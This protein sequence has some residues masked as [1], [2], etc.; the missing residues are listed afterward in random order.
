V[1]DKRYYFFSLLALLLILGYL[2]YLILRPFL[3]PIGWAFV[4]SIVFFPMHRFLLRFLKWDSLAAAATAVM[5]CVLIL[6]PFSYFTYL[7]T[8]E[9]SN[10]SVQPVN[11]K[12]M[13]KILTHP[14]IAP[15]LKKGLAFLDLSQSQLQAS[16]VKAISNAGQ[17]LLEYIP[18]GL[19][20]VA[21]AA[22]HFALMAFALFFFLRDGPQF[23]A[24][25]GD[26]VPFSTKNKERLTVQ[27][28]D[29]VVSTIYGGIIVAI[30]QGL[31]GGLIFALLSIHS[32][33]LWGIGISIASFLP[34]VG[35]SIVWVPAVI[36]LLIKGALLKAVILGIVG[37]FGISMVD[38]IMRPVIMRGRL[39]MPLLAIFFSVLGGIEVFGLI[40]LV[41]GPLVLAVFVSVV[42]ILRDVEGVKD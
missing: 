26:F 25:I 22:V 32:P 12:G 24:R 37:A 27:V 5:V 14:A 21:G 11:I 36:F 42:D 23:L 35:A 31:I 39:R 13:T 15:A 6:G 4:F 18:G 10:V 2:T 9:L 33:V 7:L 40:G 20:D 34:I 3:T 30:I 16:L 8:A 29:I 41:M 17:K 28:K 1:D 19:G 38:N